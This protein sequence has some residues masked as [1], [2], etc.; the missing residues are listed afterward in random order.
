MHLTIHAY[1]GANQPKALW[2]QK[3][4]AFI[5]FHSPYYHC[6]DGIFWKHTCKVHLTWVFFQHITMEHCPSQAS[7]TWPVQIENNTKKIF[8]EVCWIGGQNKLRADYCLLPSKH[9]A[10]GGDSSSPHPSGAATVSQ[11][12]Q[13]CLVPPWLQLTVHLLVKNPSPATITAIAPGTSVGS[14]EILP[15]FQWARKFL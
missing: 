7:F 4:T 9:N 15:S 14:D 5:L 12:W 11:S 2:E 8:S 13:H 6:W 1:S 10:W 3:V